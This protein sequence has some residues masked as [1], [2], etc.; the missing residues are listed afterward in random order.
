[1]GE[2]PLGMKTFEGIVEE[3]GMSIFMQGTHKLVDGKGELVALLQSGSDSLDL[4]SYLGQKVKVSG[5]SEPSVEGGATF[6]TVQ[7]VSKL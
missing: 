3:L 4:N 1:V 5:A 6:V 2:E 7:S